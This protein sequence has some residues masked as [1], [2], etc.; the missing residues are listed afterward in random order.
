MIFFER[1]FRGASTN[2]RFRL[3][4]GWSG[5]SGMSSAGGGIVADSRMDT[6]YREML[7]KAAVFFRLFDPSAD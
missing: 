6:E 5:I 1:S 2:L 4:A 7:D 3:W